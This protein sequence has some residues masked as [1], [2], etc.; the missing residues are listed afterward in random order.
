MISTCSSSVN[1]SLLLLFHPR[2]HLELLA[3]FALCMLLVVVGKSTIMQRKTCE[4]K[5]YR[6]S[7][8]FRLNNICKIRPSQYSLVQSQQ[9]QHQKKV[10][11]LLKVNKLLSTLEIFHT[12]WCLLSW[13]WKIKCLLG[14]KH[15][16][17][18]QQYMVRKRF[19]DNILKNF[20]SELLSIFLV[21]D[22]KIHDD[23]SIL[24]YSLTPF[25]TSVW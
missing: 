6:K 13:L 20:D 12:F 23:W 3:G 8:T 2:L 21:R 16:T 5:K 7:N 4:V 9:W 10:W 15:V 17:V 25:T 18:I 14:R 1:F 11:N 19:Y 24:V 22:K